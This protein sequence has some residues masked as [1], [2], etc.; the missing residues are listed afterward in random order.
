MICAE[1]DRQ[2]HCGCGS[3]G[4]PEPDLRES[5]NGSWG[6]DSRG[7]E[8]VCRTS[9]VRSGE[10]ERSEDMLGV[11]NIHFSSCLGQEKKWT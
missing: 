6:S 11:V 5:E 3:P 2:E 8:L 9:V 10:F 7:E 1:T 4:G